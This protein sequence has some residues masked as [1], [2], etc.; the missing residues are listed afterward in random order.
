MKIA[1]TDAC[2]FIDL[3]DIDLI[4]EFIQLP[5]E[6]HTTEQVFIELEP[7]QQKQLKTAGI[8]VYNSQA[9]DYLKIEDIG[10]PRSLSIADKSVLYLALKLDATVLSS[11]KVVR[12]SA[13][14]RSIDYHGMLWIFDQLIE[15]SIL[16][17]VDALSKMEVLIEVNSMFK[18]NKKLMKE[19]DYRKKNWL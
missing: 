14:I 2:I 17:K 7:G 10:L 1:V 13:K 5:F 11:D 3:F 15:N 9:E 8:H 4:K 19:I 18:G 16:S 6:I 12:N